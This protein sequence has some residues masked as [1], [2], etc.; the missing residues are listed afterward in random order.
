MVQGYVS[1]ALLSSGHCIS[2]FKFKTVLTKDGEAIGCD[3][4]GNP[5]GQ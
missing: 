4:K 5:S 3:K 1:C 2:L